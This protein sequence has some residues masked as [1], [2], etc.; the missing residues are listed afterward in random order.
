MNTCKAMGAR[1]FLCTRE[2]GHD[3]PHMAGLDSEQPPKK[4][5]EPAWEE[6]PENFEF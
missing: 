4:L 2:E 6:N 3:L 5:A 1:G